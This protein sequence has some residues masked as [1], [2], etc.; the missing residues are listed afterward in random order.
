MLVACLLVLT[1]SLQISCSTRSGFVRQCSPRT[2]SNSSPNIITASSPDSGF[3]ALCLELN[4][5]I[6]E[7]AMNQLGLEGSYSYVNFSDYEIKNWPDF[8]PFHCKNWDEQAVKDLRVAL[9]NLIFKPRPFSGRKP[10]ASDNSMEFRTMNR[11]KLLDKL[12]VLFNNQTGLGIKRVP[13]VQ[14][15]LRDWPLGVSFR[16]DH[17]RSPEVLALSRHLDRIKFVKIEGNERRTVTYTDGTCAEIR[18]QNHQAYLL[19]GQPRPLN[20]RKRASRRRHVSTDESDF[21]SSDSEMELASSDSES[22]QHETTAPDSSHNSNRNVDNL[23]EDDSEDFGIISEEDELITGVASET[24]IEDKEVGIVK[25][26]SS[27]CYTDE[28]LRDYDP[29]MDTFFDPE[30]ES[31]L[32]VSKLTK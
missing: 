1:F 16:A 12:V 10:F 17:W 19:D 9:P 26:G 13:W 22:V 14:Y 3:K 11:R 28:L 8:V 6:K 23:I 15:H 31:F 30:I 5:E 27:E 7:F 20:R 2:T 21:E 24:P 18:G 4:K 32:N 25:F 29:N